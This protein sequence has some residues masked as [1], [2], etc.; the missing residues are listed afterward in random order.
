MCI[1][2]KV[3]CPTLRKNYRFHK[4]LSRFFIAILSFIFFHLHGYAQNNVPYAQEVLDTH[5]ELEET[6]PYDWFFDLDKM[7]CHTFEEKDTL[8]GMTCSRLCHTWI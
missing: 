3:S 1:M 2:K 5:S 7:T 4:N 8:P 6:T